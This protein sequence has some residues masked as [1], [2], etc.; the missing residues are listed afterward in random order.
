MND[1]CFPALLVMTLPGAFPDLFDQ[2]PALAQ[3]K[4]YD[5]EDFS[6][7]DSNLRTVN[8][9]GRVPARTGLRQQVKC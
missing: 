7:A 6:P 4:I 3:Q 9:D 1:E 5:R 8:C 2:L